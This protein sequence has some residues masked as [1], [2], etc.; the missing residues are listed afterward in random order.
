MRLVLHVGLPKTG[1]THLQ[2]Q[3]FEH[4]EALGALGVGV[5]ATATKGHR[6]PPYNLARELLGDPAFDPALGTWQ[7]LSEELARMTDPIAFLSCEG[8]AH[9]I[10]EE[11]HLARLVELAETAGRSLTILAVVREPIA[12]L[13]STYQQNVRDFAVTDSFDA[14]RAACLDGGFLDFEAHFASVL[15]H[16][17]ID[18]VALS[19]DRFRRAPPLESLARV[20]GLDPA[21]V[22]G[23]PAVEG[24]ENVSVGP[25][26]VALARLLGAALQGLAPGFSSADPR[27]R[28]IRRHFR[29]RTEA[30]GWNDEPYWGWDEEGTRQAMQTVGPAL[31]RFSQAVWSEPWPDAH[32]R[33]RREND[34]GL[35][36]FDARDAATAT[37]LLSEVRGLLGEAEPASSASSTE[38]SS[39]ALAT[40]RT[41]LRGGRGK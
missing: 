36:S 38:P 39:S 31:E 26:T 25:R 8:F 18:L 6:R 23:L 5:P 32:P 17:A 40:A 1:S 10:Q 28:P 14:F 37:E 24:R 20:L 22:S 29:E 2:A 30:A 19:F 13:N 4:R 12:W 7:E 21:G 35:E 15:A 27:Y 34:V 3:V 9:G 41:W 11:V 33:G 16:P